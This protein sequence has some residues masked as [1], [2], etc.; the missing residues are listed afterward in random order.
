MLGDSPPGWSDKLEPKVPAVGVLGGLEER[1]SLP[2]EG[3]LYSLTLVRHYVPPRHVP[4]L[5]PLRLPLSRT[6]VS[7][8][9]GALYEGEA[10]QRTSQNSVRAKFREYPFHALC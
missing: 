2:A 8:T 5:L 7:R 6:A 1:H 4:L 10:R 9:L 3:I